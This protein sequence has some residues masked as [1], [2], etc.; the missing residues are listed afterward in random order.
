MGVAGPREGGGEGDIGDFG[1][2][3]GDGGERTMAGC[4]GGVGCGLVWEAVGGTGVIDLM[5]GTPEE[6][7]DGSRLIV[8]RE[9]L[10]EA[11]RDAEREWP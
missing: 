3:W 8:R 11:R 1:E 2:D 4:A 9:F 10:L 6:I 7:I 5:L